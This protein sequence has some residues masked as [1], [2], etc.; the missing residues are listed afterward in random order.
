MSYAKKNS[1]KKAAN[2][3]KKGAGTMKSIDKEFKDAVIISFLKVINTKDLNDA[4]ELL[5]CGDDLAGYVAGICKSSTTESV[6]DYIINT[7]YV[8]SDGEYIS[9][10]T[11]LNKA[12]KAV[13]VQRTAR[14]ETKCTKLLDMIN[15]LMQKADDDTIEM[16]GVIAQVLSQVLDNM[17]DISSDDATRI[18]LSIVLN[19]VVCKTIDICDESGIVMS[20]VVAEDTAASKTKEEK[21]EETKETKTE[22]N[23]SIEGLIDSVTTIFIDNCMDMWINQYGES[24]RNEIAAAARQAV[25][26]VVRDTTDLVTLKND[27]DKFVQDNTF[28]VLS[29][30]SD[31]MKKGA[32]VAVSEEGGLNSDLVRKLLA[33]VTKDSLG[34]L[35]SP[36]ATLLLG[37]APRSVTEKILA[38]S[39]EDR[40]LA[41]TKK[42]LE[43]KGYTNQD[44]KD[45]IE[46]PKHELRTSLVKKF[47]DIGI[48]GIIKSSKESLKEE[49]I[50]GINKLVES[51]ANTH[52]TLSKKEIDQFA[53]NLVGTIVGDVEVLNSTTDTH[54][55][56]E[57]NANTRDKDGL[58]RFQEGSVIHDETREKCNEL[59]TEI[60]RN[61][62]K[63]AG[64]TE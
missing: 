64:L 46:D 57:R 31:I 28:K 4:M 24:R 56:E 59:I 45:A 9:C 10:M 7:D 12:V 5:A 52:I 1:K 25:G 41:D 62:R 3:D 2:N 47:K 61:A 43:G 14:K 26:M 33:A 42:A 22:E 36:V 16:S 48:M 34:L 30:L 54:K 35:K 39:V 17:V 58:F 21:T 38:L 13:K 49:I 8:L 51:R 53:D 40:D 27:P 18:A 32:Q 11:V 37:I 63:K 15:S 50:N 55:Q 20:Q 6:E 19:A 60:F 23:E 29:L 44:L